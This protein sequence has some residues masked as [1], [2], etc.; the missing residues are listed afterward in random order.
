MPSEKSNPTL[1]YRR[2]PPEG[3]EQIASYGQLNHLK[4]FALTDFVGHRFAI[5]STEG[6]SNADRPKTRRKS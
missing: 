4:R 6:I 2:Q 3:R 5:A 1:D